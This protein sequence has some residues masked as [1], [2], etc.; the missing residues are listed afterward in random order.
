MDRGVMAVGAFMLVLGVMFVYAAAPL[1]DL[2]SVGNT[3][4]NPGAEN[5][6][7]IVGVILAPLGAAILAYG[8]GSAPN[9]RY[10]G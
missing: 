1:V 3:A 2:G 7:I 4:Y 8:T 6:F 10:R 5:R 9:E